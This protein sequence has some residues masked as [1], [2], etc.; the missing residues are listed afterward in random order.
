M[1]TLYKEKTQKYKCKNKINK[2]AFINRTLIELLDKLFM[3]SQMLI[4]KKG[5]FHTLCYAFAVLKCPP[6]IIQLCMIF[7]ERESLRGKLLLGNT[8]INR[9][10]K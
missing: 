3:S 6:C 8:Y 4:L 10:I 1:L 2:N 5:F 9:E 7:I